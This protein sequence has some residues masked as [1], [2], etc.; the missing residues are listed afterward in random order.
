MTKV[1]CKVYL[2]LWF[3]RDKNPSWQGHLA[4]FQ[5]GR[6]FSNSDRHD[7][8]YRNLGAHIFKSQA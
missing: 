7:G 1:I 5:L 8:R 6:D 4:I 2:G 3:Y